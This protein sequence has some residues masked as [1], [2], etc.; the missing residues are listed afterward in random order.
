MTLVKII[1]QIPKILIQIKRENRWLNHFLRKERLD[2]VISDNRYGL[3]SSDTFSVFI[4]HQLAIKTPFG[5]RIEHKLLQ[6]NY[7]YINRF[8][9]CWIPDFGEAHSLAGKLAHPP[10]LPAFTLPGRL[11]QIYKKRGTGDH[12]PAGIVIGARATAKYTR[13]QIIKRAGKL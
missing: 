1:F 9:I 2:A 3:Y 10:S 7:G 13:K 11:N 6:L 12:R 4:T 5:K 8:A